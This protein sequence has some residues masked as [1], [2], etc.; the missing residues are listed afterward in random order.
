MLFPLKG[1]KN[2]TMRLAVL[3][4]ALVM[5]VVA[6]GCVSRVNVGYY[7]DN[8]RAA[9]AALDTLNQRLSVGDYDAIYEQTAGELR[10][11]PKAEVVEHMKQTHD[12]WGKFIK[13]EVKSSNCQFY[14]VH[15]LVQAQFENGEVGEIAVWDVRDN[16]AHLRQ[17]QIALG[18]VTVPSGL[19][20]NECRSKGQ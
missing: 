14:E 17:F 19:N 7:D 16:R 3:F 15:L 8:K 11:R 9:V 13:A 5:L 1:R 10:A 6:F 20:P 18:S 4:I 2:R 12:R